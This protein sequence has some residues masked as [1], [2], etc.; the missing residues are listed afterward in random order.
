[1][2]VL[3]IL[4]VMG[5][6]AVGAFD[7]DLR[8]SDGFDRSAVES[9]AV[10]EINDAREENGLPVLEER[11]SLTER[12]RAYSAEIAAAG[13]L[14][15][16][17]VACSPGGENIAK[18]YWQRA[19]QTD[20]GVETYTTNEELGEALAQQWLTSENH[21]ENIMSPQFAVVGVGVVKQDDE[22]YAT[23]RLCG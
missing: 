4:A 23:Q 7:G 17:S 11:E 8:I 3:A 1:V 21:R 2:V 9:T 19:V 15:H 5:V 18:S 22:V 14:E 16:G 12:S 10:E 6:A 20:S 13:E